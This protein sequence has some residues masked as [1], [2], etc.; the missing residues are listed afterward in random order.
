M[1]ASKMKAVYSTDPS[2]PAQ[3]LIS[4]I[5]YPQLHKF[6]TAATTW[7]CEHEAIARMAYIISDYFSDYFT[8]LIVTIL[9]VCVAM[10]VIGTTCT[11]FSSTTAPWRTSQSSVC[12][13]T[14]VTEAL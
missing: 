6:T 4:S 11:P 9:G 14:V 8:L 3:S 5:C 7:G 12:N 1:T 13:S 2:N 10:L